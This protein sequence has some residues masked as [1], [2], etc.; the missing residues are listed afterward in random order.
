MSDLYPFVEYR[1]PWTQS[2]VHKVNSDPG[3][4]GIR[5][6]LR[7]TFF[8]RMLDDNKPCPRIIVVLRNPKDILVSYFHFERSRSD[9]QMN[10]TFE[11]FFARYRDNCLQFGDVIDHIVSWWSYRDHPCVHI[12][13]YEDLLEDFTRTIRQ[14]AKF[15]GCSLSME[16]EERVCRESSLEAMRSRG[17]SAYY[18][19][20]LVDESVQPFFRKAIK[21]DWRTTFSN[22]QKDYVDQHIKEKLHPLGLYLDLDV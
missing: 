12:V 16:D 22:E 10:E 8:Q 18:K 17:V 9:I 21:G 15:L 2:P 7:P 19:G 13:F 1:A 6:H 11:E 20:T 4:V 14:L 3:I 5:T